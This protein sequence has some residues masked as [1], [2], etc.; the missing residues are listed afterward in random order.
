MTDFT[1]RFGGGF[2]AMPLDQARAALMRRLLVQG[3][4]GTTTAPG[5]TLNAPPVAPLVT[6]P[7]QAQIPAGA[8]TAPTADALPPAPTRSVAPVQPPSAFPAQTGAVP[9]TASPT[10]PGG[11]TLASNPVAPGWAG[12]VG[13][14]GTPASAAPD[15]TADWGKAMEGMAGLTKALQS[16]V[17]PAAI[18]NLVGSSGEQPNQPSSL[19]FDLMKQIMQSKQRG[20]T[21]T[22]RS[23]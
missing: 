3:A 13:L 7:P 14:P 16:K 6:F 10:G 23:G 15:A 22:G 9:Y 1:D 18:P 17:T 20:L 21:L 4:P 11:I 2:G 8:V 12:T 5:T 19:A